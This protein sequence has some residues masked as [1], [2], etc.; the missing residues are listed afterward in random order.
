M[1][2]ADIKRLERAAD[3]LNKASDLMDTIMEKEDM[4][5]SDTYYLRKCVNQYAYD[6][7]TLRRIVKV[8]RE[9]KG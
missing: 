5:A 8:A 3:M 1:K 9:D 7:N 6:A 2:E 4:M